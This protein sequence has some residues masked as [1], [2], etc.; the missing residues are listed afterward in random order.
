MPINALTLG[1]TA[2][3]TDATLVDK[4]LA[5]DAQVG[6]R[7]PNV[8]KFNG[9]VSAEVRR[10]LATDNRSLFARA[11]L[12]YIGNSYTEFQSLATAQLVPASAD[13][14]ASIGMS[15][16]AWDLSLYGKNLTNRYIVTG[17][18]TDRNVPLTYAVAPPRTIGVEA[19]FRF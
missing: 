8:P 14:D 1:A 17:V 3:H 7:V 11:V 2:S 10:P 5:F 16:N 4:T 15:V 13:L 12:S 9:N 18:D 19:R 6:D